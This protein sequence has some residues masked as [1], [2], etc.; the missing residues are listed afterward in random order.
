M[1]HPN[2][3]LKQTLTESQCSTSFDAGTLRA[4]AVLNNLAPSQCKGRL[5][6]LQVF[7][8]SSIHSKGTA[9]PPQLLCEF[10]IHTRIGNIQMLR[11]KMA[12][13]FENPSMQPKVELCPV[14]AQKQTITSNS[15]PIYI[16][17]SGLVFKLLL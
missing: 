14:K 11:I 16:I 7:D 9:R 3:L 12:Q 2:P 17:Q 5:K 4:T 15:H 1:G 8:N 6:D 13:T 10:S